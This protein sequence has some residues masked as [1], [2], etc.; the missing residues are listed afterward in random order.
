M[1]DKST[2]NSFDNLNLNDREQKTVCPF[3]VIT[4][5]FGCLQNAKCIVQRRAIH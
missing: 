5:N 2:E 3:V 1:S 4:N